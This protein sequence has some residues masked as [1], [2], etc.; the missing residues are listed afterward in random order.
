[1]LIPIISLCGALSYL[2]AVNV[3]GCLL[4]VESGQIERMLRGIIIVA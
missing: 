2:S 3:F 1:M 4:A